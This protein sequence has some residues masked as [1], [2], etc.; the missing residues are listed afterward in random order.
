MVG[1]AE[2]NP[3]KHSCTQSGGGW[4]TQGVAILNPKQMFWVPW[5]GLELRSESR[6]LWPLTPPSGRLV[7][8][9]HPSVFMKGRTHQQ[10]GSVLSLTLTCSSLGAQRSLHFVL[11]MLL[12]C[13]SDGISPSMTQKL[14]RSSVTPFRLYSIRPKPHPPII[15]HLVLPHLGFLLG[16]TSSRPQETLWFDLEDLWRQRSRGSLKGFLAGCLVLWDIFD[17]SD[18][19][20]RFYSHTLGFT[21]GTCFS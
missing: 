20:K 5:L 8:T 15:L 9:C 21:F 7:L 10:L 2:G 19:K 16:I 1:Q 17:S 14:R 4:R 18:L 13:Q 6:S 12:S 3:Y 11:S